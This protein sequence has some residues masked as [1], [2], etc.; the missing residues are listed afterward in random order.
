MRMPAGEGMGISAGITMPPQTI[1]RKAN[2]QALNTPTGGGL[3]RT[4]GQPLD[5]GS[6]EFFEPR[7][8]RNLGGV[9]IHTESDADDLAGNIS[10]TA[11][12]LGN[13]IGFAQ[14][15]YD[16][17]SS[18]G[19]HLLAHELAHVG[20]SVDVIQRQRTPTPVIETPPA[21]GPDVTDW[22]V[23]IMNSAKTNSTVVAIEEN[24]ARARRI[25]ARY[26]YSSADVLE[27]GLARRVLAAEAAAGHP[28]RTADATGQLGQADPQNQFGRA[29]IG[30]TVPLPFVGMPEQIMFLSLR[31]AGEAWKS[32]VQTGAVWD[33]KNNVL[34]GT[35]LATAN[36]SNSCPAPPTVTICGTCF[37]HDLPG[38][39]FYAYIGGF[40]GFSLNALQLGSQ[41]AEL[42]PNSTST[43]DSRE[44]TA[45]IKFGFYL[46]AT[47]TGSD[48][49]TALS[50]AAGGVT[51]RPCSA[52]SA[53]Y[54]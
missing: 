33:F 45:A 46:P 44:D 49:C 43:W 6:R 7:F 39:L 14:G 36:C 54:P 51:I 18:T 37:E 53:L 27:G 34:N 41:F 23:S 11:F 3:F 32:L 12:T 21:C 5:T 17:A 40:C 22:F 31:R 47:L 13:H 10:A 38:N 35:N 30:A 15:A 29:L 48:L 24:M 42:Q 4:H 1:N 50:G 20:Q 9:R 16:P 52:C 8:G 25:G 28:T 26:G 2:G 19:K